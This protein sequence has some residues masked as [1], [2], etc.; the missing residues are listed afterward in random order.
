MFVKTIVYIVL[1]FVF[2]LFWSRVRCS[3]WSCS[4]LLQ[5]V[6]YHQHLNDT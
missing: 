5:H 1:L 2:S 6:F 3:W 4:I